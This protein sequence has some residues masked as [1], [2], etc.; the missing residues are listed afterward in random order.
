MTGIGFV[1][2]VLEAIFLLVLNGIF[3]FP[4]EVK[5]KLVIIYLI[6]NYIV[7]RYRGKSLLMYDEIRLI[8]LSNFGFFLLGLLMIPMDMFRV[9]VLLGVFLLVCAMTFFSLLCSRY[10]HIFLRSFFKK[11]VMVIGIGNSAF[12]L[13]DVIK[14]NRFSLMEVKCFID[15]N[16]LKNVNQIKHVTK[17][18]VYLLKDLEKVI[19][20]E[21]INVV[22]LAIP[23]MERKEMD[24]I[25]SRVVNKVD[26]IKYLP[27]IQNLVTFD[28]KVDDFDG[29]LL[30]SS[31]NGGIKPI[32]RLFKRCMDI[33][34]GLAG[35]ILLIPITL[36]I[37]IYNRKEGDK[38]P[39]IFTQSRIGKNGKEFKLYKFRTMVVNAEQILDELMEKDPAIKEEYLTNKKLINDPRITKAGKFLR[40]TSLDEFPQFINVLKGEMSL[41][42][43]R[44]YLPREK[45]DMGE[46]YQSIIACTPGLT[47]MWQTHGR[48][49]TSFQERLELDEYYYRNWSFWLDVTIISKTI[50]QVLYGKGAM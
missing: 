48:S 24:M 4:S 32:S 27:Q 10:S 2:F 41:I 44:P 8:L 5:I 1:N 49:E 3:S 39:L 35:M 19:D 25:F 29:M 38:G 23:E 33:C 18:P 37:Y 20:R 30:I 46:Y 6:I 22:M 15:C 14:R 42:G 28:T 17:E 45:E 12:T 43:P 11:R 16:E 9:K 21:Q 47:G 7:G 36:Y 26:S 31:S 34:A 40:E 13:A 50:R